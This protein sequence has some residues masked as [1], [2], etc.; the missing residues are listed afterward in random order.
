MDIVKSHFGKM[1]LWPVEHFFEHIYH[2]FWVG[3][4]A[5][6]QGATATPPKSDDKYAQKSVQLVRGS[7]F[8][9]DFLQNPYFRASWIKIMVYQEMWKLINTTFR[10][11]CKPYFFYGNFAPYQ[12]VFRQGF[13]RFLLCV[14]FLTINEIIVYVHVLLLCTYVHISW[15]T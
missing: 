2:H 6:P 3:A 11:T 4:A 12:K 14:W 10:C 15:Y 13:F 1:N 7:S 8:R 5:N 9:S